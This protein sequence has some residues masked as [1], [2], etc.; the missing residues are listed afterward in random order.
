MSIFAK[1]ATNVV[2]VEKN[3]HA[4]NWGNLTRGFRARGPQKFW[5][6]PKITHFRLSGVRNFPLTTFARSSLVDTGGNSRIAGGVWPPSPKNPKI[7]GA[8]GAN[9]RIAISIKLN[10]L[11]TSDISTA[12]SEPFFQIS[13]PIL[14]YGVLKIRGWGT[15][16]VFPLP[17][18]K[19]PI[20]PLDVIGLG[21]L[22]KT[23]F[24]WGRSTP[25][26]GRYKG[27][28]ICVFSLFRQLWPT[29]PR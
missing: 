14:R 16:G 23:L 20:S 22:T 27:L 15:F 18:A 6:A 26:W 9:M 8:P 17:G 12:N 3:R 29:V 7:G 19:P 1:I 13:F 25:I 11:D 10:F 21:T 24:E 28:K 5:G 4:Q 2:P